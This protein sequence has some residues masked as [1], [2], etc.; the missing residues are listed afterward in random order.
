MNEFN[1]NKKYNWELAHQP[2]VKTYKAILTQTGTSA[3]VAN[4]LVNTLGEGISIDWTYTGVGLYVATLT[5]GEFDIT[6]TYV[7]IQPDY[8]AASYFTFAGVNPSLLSTITV[9]SENASAVN[10]NIAGNAFI[11]INIYG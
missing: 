10:V 11:E 1:L 7:Q 8:Y 4:V 9:E 5:K 2:I 6:N 3:P